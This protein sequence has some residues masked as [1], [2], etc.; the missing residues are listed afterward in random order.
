VE[1]N[2][3]KQKPVYLD[4]LTLME[5][6]KNYAS[7]KSKITQMV[8]TGALIKVRRG[9]YLD[10][11]ETN[12]SIKTLA[13][14]ICYPSYISFEYALSYYQ[15]IPERVEIVTSASFQKNKNK[16]FL[17][18]VGTFY[19]FYLDPFIYHYGIDRLEECGHS[20]FIATREKALLDT[21]S[22]IKGLRSVKAM[23]SLLMDD[24]RINESIFPELDWKEIFNLSTKYH[25]RNGR[26]LVEWWERRKNE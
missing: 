26:T 7:P 16:V 12:Y 22:K 9:L 23:Q 6:Y 8:K 18:P 21:L 20:F 15:M 3:Q 5:R 4:H 10:S 13:N 14:L 24:L 17:T 2:M 19:Y 25:Q 1:Q 11:E